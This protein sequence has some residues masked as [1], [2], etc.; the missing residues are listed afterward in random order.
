MQMS[1]FSSEE[2]RASRSVSQDFAKDW[3]TLGETSC[4]PTL[5]LLHGIAPAGW[6]GRTSPEFYRVQK[7]EISRPSSEGW[8]SSGMGGPTACLT[9][10]TSEWPSDAA[11]CSLSDTLETGPVPR[12]FYLSSRACAGI[13]RRSVRQGLA[14]PERLRQALEMVATARHQSLSTG[15]ATT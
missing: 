2:P 4:S 8:A 5:R 1:M 12:R 14:L 13:L 9:L 7:G 15:M 10:N 3:L 6:F 11:V